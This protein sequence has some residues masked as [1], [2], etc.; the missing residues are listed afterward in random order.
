[1][2]ECLR[3]TMEVALRKLLSPVDKLPAG[4]NKV[5]NVSLLKLR[6]KFVKKTLFAI[7]KD[8]FFQ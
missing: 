3:Y 8:T 6:I 7:P 5:V 4:I 2:P 1:M